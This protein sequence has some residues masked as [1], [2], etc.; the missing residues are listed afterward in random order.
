M[1]GNGAFGACHWCRNGLFKMGV[2]NAPGACSRVQP[3]PGAFGAERE[4]RFKSRRAAL[5]EGPRRIAEVGLGQQ[6]MR[7]LADRGKVCR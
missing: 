2:F 5:I 1:G 6:V 4:G 7:V 3:G